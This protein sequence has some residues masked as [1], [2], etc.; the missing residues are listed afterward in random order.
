[1]QLKHLKVSN[2]RALREVEMPL[3]AFVCLASRDFIT[4]FRGS[5]GTGKSFTL[6][7][8]MRG[9]RA[10]GHPVVVLAPQRQQ[11]ADLCADGLAAKTLS[12]CLETKTLPPR[13]VVLVGESGQI[14]GKQLGE[15]VALVKA[16]GGR[17][18]L[19]GDTRQHGAVQASD[20][21]PAPDLRSREEPSARPLPRWMR[22]AAGSP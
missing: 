7:E 9:L 20:E 1:M 6:R 13:A 12:H 18:I 3:S 22:Y 21:N 11:V 15:L 16:H 8:V 5:A 17:L 2:Y 19:S 10:A 4:L 14:G